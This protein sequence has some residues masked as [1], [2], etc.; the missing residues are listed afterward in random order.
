MLPGASCF[1]R[2]FGPSGLVDTRLLTGLV[3]GFTFVLCVASTRVYAVELS[4]VVTG[5][6]GPVLTNVMTLLDIAREKDGEKLKS[7]RVRKLHVVAPQQ[8]KDALQ[9]FGYYRAQVSGELVEGEDKLSASYHVI[10]GPEITVADVDVRLTG[11]GAAV[12]TDLV[13]NFPVRKGQVFLH[14][15]YEKAKQELLRAAARN[16]YLDAQFT[17]RAV[18]VN[19]AT[20]TVAVV[21]HMDTGS[22]YKFGPV[23]F[24]QTPEA[25]FRDDFL[26]GFVTIEPGQMFRRRALLD[27]QNR[28]NDSQYFSGVSVSANR[29]D[30]QALSI[31]IRVELTANKQHRYRF[32]AGFGT[33]TGPRASFGYARRVNPDGHLLDSDLKLSTK[34]SVASIQYLIPLADPVAER[35]ALGTSFVDESTDSRDSRIIKT[36]AKRTLMRSGW[37]ESV[38]VNFE[39]ED[40]QVGD[41]DGRSTLLYPAANWS[42]IDTDDR[43]FPTRGW[44]LGFDLLGAE[45]SL[46]SDATFLQARGAGKW[47]KTLSPRSRILVRG[48]LGITALA[49]VDDLPGSKRFFAGGDQ[50][51]RG[52]EFE[53]LGPKNALGEVIGGKYLVVG[54]AEYER[55]LRGNWGAAVFVDAGNAFNDM[56]ES[57]KKSVGLGV[58][59]RSPVGPIRVD[60]AHPLGD[61]DEGG[62]Q[63]HVVIGPDL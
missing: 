10:P 55:R 9:P 49:A 26:M 17:R 42:R 27:L 2:I 4:V 37:L 31:P 61:D 8:I 59:Y 14:Q 62:I 46:G 5:V 35:L 58:R 33:D 54:S 50:S 1:L 56:G 18:T 40:F 3:L 24:V 13:D 38:S 43:L 29:Q 48:E 22:Q 52:Y 23:E 63:L 36:S 28:F 47:I 57:L 16:G 32:G 45:E 60:I 44:R 15:P 51:V 53:A 6:D 20:Y 12:F 30:A 21:L 39:A 7:S 25:V 11:A 34:S 41:E 19:L